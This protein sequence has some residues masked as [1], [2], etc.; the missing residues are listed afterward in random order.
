MQALS[1]CG[2]GYTRPHD[3]E[4]SWNQ[5]LVFCP[6]CHFATPKCT[7]AFVDPSG[8]G[9]VPRA[10]VSTPKQWW[11]NRTRSQQVAN[12]CCG[13]HWWQQQSHIAAICSFEIWMTGSIVSCA[14][15]LELF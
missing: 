4:S 10:V 8:A 9:C 15:D 12:T 5:L 11:S 3:N 1:F 14:G 7:T 2:S 13:L 6:S